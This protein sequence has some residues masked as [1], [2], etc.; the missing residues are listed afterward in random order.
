[1]NK[2][3]KFLIICLGV[4]L[5]LTLYAKNSNQK[6]KEKL[7][8]ITVPISLSFIILYLF[9]LRKEGNEAEGLIWWNKVRPIHGTLYL[10]FSIY[11]FKKENFSWIFLLIDTILGLIF[12]YLRYYHNLIFA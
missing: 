9:D 6:S 2:T 10:L 7:L 3:L 12:W 8:F 4:R 5:M 1:M 11:T